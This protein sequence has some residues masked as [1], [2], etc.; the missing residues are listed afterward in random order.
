MVPPV[1]TLIALPTPPAPALPP[2]SL[3]APFS[4]SPLL[5]APPVPSAMIP[6]DSVNGNGKTGSVLDPD[7]V[8][9]PLLVIVIEPELAPIELLFPVV[10]PIEDAKMAE[11]PASS[12][13][14]EPELP[15]LI[16]PDIA[17]GAP[18]S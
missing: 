7:V 1:L 6:F 11:L 15:T 13:V 10:P 8:I 3:P 12:V 17:P 16:L 18:L 5:P 14:I 4:F 2:L 9:A